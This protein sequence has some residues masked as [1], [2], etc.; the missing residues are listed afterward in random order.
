MTHYDFWFAP[1]Q[2]ETFL[3]TIGQYDRSY[4]DCLDAATLAW[5]ALAPFGNALTRHPTTGETPVEFRLRVG[6]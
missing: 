6:K 3:C 2:G 1:F 4:R 5:E